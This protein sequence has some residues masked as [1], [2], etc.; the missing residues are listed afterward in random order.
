MTYDK[1]WK[2]RVNDKRVRTASYAGLFTIIP[3]VQGENTVTMKFTPPGMRF[4]TF[5]T[6]V[7]LLLWIAYFIVSR[8]RREFIESKS[9]FVLATVNSKLKNVYALVFLIV[10][11]KKRI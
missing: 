5:I 7:V 3:L 2:V 10:M 1:G 6:I 11:L 8:I 4:G 9:E